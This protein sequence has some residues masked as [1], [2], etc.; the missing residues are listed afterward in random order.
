MASPGGVTVHVI[1]WAP[2]GFPFQGGPT[3][4]PTYE[5]LIE[6]YF[7]DVAHDSS[8]MSGAAC[9]TF[10]CDDFTVEPQ[11]GF[12]TTPGGITSGQNKINFSSSS[13]AFTGSESLPST[14]DVI[15]DSSPYPTAGNGPGQCSS[16]QDTKACILDSALQTEVDNIV[17]HTSGTPRGLN[18]LWHVFL[19]PNV[20]ECISQ[21][22]CG[23]NAFGG[24]TRCRTSTVTA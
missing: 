5:G 11:Y 14:A 20:D 22:V 1:F 7:T 10:A 8:G 23:T 19:P 16:P 3:G 24:Y 21:D 13:A 12:G 15:L 9:T 4:A 2:S 17:Q 6:Q 18:N